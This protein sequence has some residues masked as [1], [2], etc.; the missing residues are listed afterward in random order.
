[1]T[2]ETHDKTSAKRGTFW[3]KKCTSERAGATRDKLSQRDWQ[4]TRNYGITVNE[5]EVLLNAKNENCWICGNPK[6]PNGKRLAVDHKHEKGEKR[7]NPR[8][9]RA[10]VRGLLCW[11]CNGAIGKFKDNPALMRKAADYIESNLAQQLLN[12]ETQ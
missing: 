2:P 7:R 8:E 12:K 10:R 4:L 6:P 9:K 5:Y 11:Q 1:L 3:C